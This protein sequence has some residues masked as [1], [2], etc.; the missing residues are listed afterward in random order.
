MQTAKCDWQNEPKS[1]AEPDPQPM[2]L[3]GVWCNTGLN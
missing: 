2:N 3:Y 1:H